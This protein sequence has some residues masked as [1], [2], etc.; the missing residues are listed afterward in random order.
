MVDIAVRWKM[1]FKYILQLIILILFS[2][3]PYTLYSQEVFDNAP[4]AMEWKQLLTPHFKIIYPANFEDNAQKLANKLEA[5]YIPTSETLDAYPKRIPIILQN[6]NSVSNGFV[7]LSPRRSE[8]YTMPPQDY[9]FLGTNTWLDL[10]SIHEFRHV[11]QFEKSKTGITKAARYVFGQ[12]GQAALAVI[13]APRWFWEGD[14][15]LIETLHTPSGRGRIPAFNRIYRTNTLAKKRYSYSKQHLRSYKDIIPDHYVLGYNYVTHLRRRTNDPEVWEKVTQSAFSWPIVPFTFSNA[16]KKHTGLNVRKNYQSMQDEL[17]MLWKEQEKKLEPEDYNLILNKEPKVF[18]SYDYPQLL[19]DGRVV[20]LKS[21]LGDPEHF[22]VLSEKGKEIKRYIPG[23]I[24]GAGFLSMARNRLVWN[25]IFVDKRWRKVSSSVIKAYDF[26]KGE[27]RT[28]TRNTRYSGAAISPDGYK[29]L[30][31]LSTEDQQN[32]LVVINYFSGEELKRFSTPDNAFL[33]MAR[34]SENGEK[35]VSLMTNQQGKGVILFDYETG[36]ME[37]IIPVSHENIGHPILYNEYL[38]FNSPVNGLDNI[39]VLNTSTGQRFQVTNSRY[40]AYNPVIDSVN[41][42]IYFNDYQ[43]NGMN[44]AK[45]PFDLSQWTLLEN[46]P[47]ANVHYFEPLLDQENIVELNEIENKLYPTKDYHFLLNSINPHS[48]GLLASSDLNTLQAGIFSDD[49]LRT[50][51][52]NVGYKYDR[53]F[54]SSSYYGQVSYQGLFPI[55]DFM[56]EKGDRVDEF[57]FFNNEISFTWD[58]T[59]TQFGT[60]IPLFLTRSKFHSQLEAGYKIGIRNISNFNNDSKSILRDDE[61]LIPVPDTDTTVLLYLLPTKIKEGTLAFDKI[62][63]SYYLLQKQSTRDLNSRWGAS[64]S[65]ESYNTRNF[66]NNDFKGGLLALRSTVY[67]PSP[68]FLLNRNWFKHHSFYIRYHTQSREIIKDAD[69]YY[70]GNR[71]FLPR[72]YGHSHYSDFTSI[73]FNYKFP[74]LYPDLRIGPLVYIK[75]IK[76]NA[77]FDTG[78]GTY[79]AFAYREG[80][81]QLLSGS[82]ERNFKSVGGE[83][84]FDFNIMRFPVN[85]DLGVRYA[86][87]LDTQE[88]TVEFPLLNIQF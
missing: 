84:M 51:R 20:A 59:T 43:P 46:A 60:R 55:L 57:S 4:P 3:F 42:Q 54:G 68:V 41:Q 37:N 67:L 86:Y 71:I 62:E 32:F 88:S 34:F 22:V 66:F 6:R 27:S 19:E 56:F 17:K 70:F 21:G 44:I 33:S 45:I 16:L 25:E 1:C 83:L 73:S 31:S 9:N 12:N 53:A 18:T 13:A 26:E 76:A 48:W 78:S 61:R 29:V 77:F 80:I 52:I 7:T 39:H 49:L 63:L 10:L 40:G 11:V 47:K 35:I 30:T 74:L 36:Q 58:E 72:G 2:I 14:A 81:N 82:V 50:T 65:I 79:T 15:T 87:T 8:F 28:I 38:F 85:I 24:N 64:V 75:R 5:M 69:L 23:L